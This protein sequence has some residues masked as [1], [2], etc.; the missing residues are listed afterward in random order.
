M[1]EK[2]EAK[3]KKSTEYVVLERSTD[4]QGTF[5]EIG[6]AEA[7]NPRGAVDRVVGEE[8]AGSFLAVPVSSYH[9]VEIEIEI[10]PPKRIVKVIKRF[11]EA[12]EP[13]PSAVAEAA[14]EMRKELEPEELPVA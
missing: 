14:R 3:V 1:S 10:P 2:V 4:S 6:V 7:S 13:E 11:G 5:T 12:S 9:L 8:V